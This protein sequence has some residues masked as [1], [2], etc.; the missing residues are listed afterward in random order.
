L[1]SELSNR[2]K[3]AAI[4]NPK[5]P[6]P[7]ALGYLR[8]LFLEDLVE[9][10]L[11]PVIPGDLRRAAEEAVIQRLP[12][13]SLGE[14]ISMA[15]RT[16]GRVAG[17]LLLDRDTKVID[18]ALENGRMTEELIVKALSLEQMT[19]AAVEKIAD[20]A[21]W[22]LMYGVKLALLRQPHTSLG[23]VLGISAS[24]KRNDLIEISGDPRMPRERRIY[25]MKLAKKAL[26]SGSNRVIER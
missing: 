3:L 23:R 4:R 17:V 22:S 21:R 13:T 2:E 15:R 9:V 6:R 24:V 16:T 14:R 8:H 12:G 19:I 26:L 10:T 7:I 11:T 18:A 20:H 25:L 5:T 1:D